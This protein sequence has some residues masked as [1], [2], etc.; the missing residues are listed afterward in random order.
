MTLEQYWVIGMVLTLVGTL[1]CT[2]LPASWVFAAVALL[3]YV[4]NSLSLNELS[5]SFTDSS[6]LTLVLLLLA[7]VALEKTRLIS[8][9]GVQLSR[10][11]LRTVLTKLWFSTSVLSS[12]TANTAVVA[13]LIGAIKRNQRYAPSKLMLP[14]AFAATFGGTLTLIGTST[15]LVINSFLDRAGLPLLQF[16]TTTGV[17]IGV[18]LAGMLVLWLIADRLPITEKAEDEQNLPYFLEAR[19]APG[20]ILIG[21][22]VSDAGLRHLRKLYLAEIQRLI[23][24]EKTTIIPVT[25]EEVLQQGDVLLFAG[26]MESVAVLQEIAGLTLY[27]HHTMNGQSLAEAI[28]SHSSSLNGVSLK[29]AQFRERFDAVVVAVR[30]GHER[31]RGGL[32]TI[33]LQAGDALLLVPGKGFGD[34]SQRLDKE[35]LLVNGVDS[36]TRL[37]PGRSAWVLASFAAVIGLAMFNVLPLMKGL[38]LFVAGLLLTQVVSLSEL[39]RRFPIDIVL[40]VGGALALSQAMGNSG[41]SKLLADELTAGFSGVHYFF[42]MAGIYLLTL[43]LTELMSNNAAAA[44]VCPISISLAQGLGIDPMPFIMAVLFGASASFISPWGYQTNL[45]V[46]TVGNYRLKQYVGVGIPMA[47]AYTFA[48]LALIPLMFPFHSL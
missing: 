10:G 13:S 8:W 25:P 22:T 32:G 23:D 43:F 18:V 46:F 40:I 36:A 45:L 24:G 12:F 48:V 4:S 30:R 21:K 33:E 28:I 5:A 20:S 44:L 2:R 6:L 41:I 38:T 14:M 17:A 1:V 19:I 34:A 42:V 9:V 16:F 47:I 31:L 3:S 29:D 39:K 11:G 27:G 37:S 26:D 7:S 15:N 35:F